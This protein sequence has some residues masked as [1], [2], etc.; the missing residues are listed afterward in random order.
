MQYIGGKKTNTMDPNHDRP[1]LSFYD[2]NPNG[3][4]PRTLMN[5]STPPKVCTEP[6]NCFERG[7]NT[8]VDG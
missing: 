3:V 4:Q 1:Y 2:I 7:E 8:Y 5:P 6:H